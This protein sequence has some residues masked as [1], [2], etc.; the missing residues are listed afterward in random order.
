MGD[1]GGQSF[2]RPGVTMLPDGGADLFV[3]GTDDAV[4]VAHRDA[5]SAAFGGFRRVGG[6][7]VS[8]LTAAVDVTGSGTRSV[9]GLGT[10]GNVWQLSDPLGGADTWTSRQVP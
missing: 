2:W 3:V 7:F 10:D 1:V 9:Y 6:V 4:W 8:G 5:G